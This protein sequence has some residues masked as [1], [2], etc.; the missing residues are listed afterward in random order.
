MAA[1]SGGEPAAWPSRPWVV[2]VATV[3]SAAMPSA[4]PSCWVVCSTPETSP[5]SAGGTPATALTIPGMNTLEDV[6][7]NTEGGSG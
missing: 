4:T 3:V 5:W 2:A 6:L 1:G 7:P